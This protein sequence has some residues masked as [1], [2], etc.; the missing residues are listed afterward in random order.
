M[1]ICTIGLALNAVQTSIPVKNA[2]AT[3]TIQMK[4]WM[5][6]T[7]DKFELPLAI[8]DTRRELSEIIGIKE[9][10]IEITRDRF[11][12]NVREKGEIDENGNY[13]RCRFYKVEVEDD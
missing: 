5:Y 4:I 12:R 2:I 11:L 9:H 10:T 7:D 8:A 13:K 6:V 1:L 3:K